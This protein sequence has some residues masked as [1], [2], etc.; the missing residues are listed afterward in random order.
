MNTYVLLPYSGSKSR[1]SDFYLPLILASTDGTAAEYVHIEKRHALLVWIAAILLVPLLPLLGPFGI[2]NA[3]RFLVLIIS[4]PPASISSTTTLYL[5]RCISPFAIFLISFIVLCAR[6]AANFVEIVHNN[7]QEYYW[8]EAV[9][10]DSLFFKIACLVQNRVASYVNAFCVPLVVRRVKT[11]FGLKLIFLSHRDRKSDSRARNGVPSATLAYNIS[12]DSVY[13]LSHSIFKHSSGARSAFERG[14]VEAVWFGDLEN[15]RNVVS[16]LSLIPFARQVGIKFR[17]CSRSRRVPAS[18]LSSIGGEYVIKSFDCSL[19]ESLKNQLPPC[20]LLTLYR[21]GVPTKFI[22]ATTNRLKVLVSPDIRYCF[23]LDIRKNLI[24]S[25]AYVRPVILF[26]LPSSFHALTSS[27]H[28]IPFA[29]LLQPQ[30]LRKFVRN[31]LVAIT[32]FLP[33]FS[34][35]R[36]SS[37]LDACLIRSDSHTSISIVNHAASVGALPLYI[38]LRLHSFA[39]HFLGTLIRFEILKPFAICFLYYSARASLVSLSSFGMRAGR[40]VV[41]NTYETSPRFLP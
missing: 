26:H 31:T 28:R 8:H 21:S 22:E 2:L 37:L 18:L 13:S 35:S 40:V 1:A 30:W 12:S 10:S 6:K 25:L 11:R 34:F 23:E 17:V 19:A 16:L 4:L 32:F 36:G 38:S 39:S 29:V 14:S 41:V 27:E 3:S 7:E 24:K 5:N 20:L 33:L 15:S 9:A